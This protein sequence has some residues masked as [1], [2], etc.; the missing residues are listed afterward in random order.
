[1]HAQSQAGLHSTAQHAEHQGFITSITIVSMATIVTIVTITVIS[2]PTLREKCTAFL[3]S[4]VYGQEQ[5]PQRREGTQQR[6]DSGVGA[7]P[8]GCVGVP[9]GGC[10]GRPA[11]ARHA[12][13]RP[14]GSAQHRSQPTVP[15]SGPARVHRAPQAATTTGLWCAS[16]TAA[17]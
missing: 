9:V 2:Q 16:S 1:M 10:D 7:H 11:R 6:G 5:S 8:E 13:S 17:P 4:S 15:I 12:A 14:R 3:V